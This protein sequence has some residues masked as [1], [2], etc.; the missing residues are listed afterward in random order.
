MITLTLTPEEASAVSVALVGL[1]H[2]P[3]PVMEPDHRWRLDASAV[4]VRLDAARRAEEQAS[5]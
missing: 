5:G 3:D 1:I 2:D 4:A